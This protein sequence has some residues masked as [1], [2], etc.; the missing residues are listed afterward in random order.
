MNYSRMTNTS[1]ATG[2]GT[3]NVTAPWLTRPNKPAQR[4]NLLT[5]RY[6]TKWLTPNLEI[7][8][9]NTIGPAI[10]M[11]E[12]AF[13]AFARGSL[14][15]T[16]D[17]PVAVEDLHPGMLVDTVGGEPQPLLWI[18]AM[19]LLPASNLPN[20]PVSHLYRIAEGSFGISSGMP[21]LLLGS[22]ARI[23][24][25]GL[26]GDPMARLIS[27]QDLCDGF[28]VIEVTPRAPARVFHLGMASHS[29]IQVNNI[30]TE[31][32]HPGHNPQMQL[33]E[34]MFQIFLSVFPHI[35]RLD[36]FGPLNHLRQVN[37]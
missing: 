36:D 3:R 16:P 29:L 34:E 35:R 2:T 10:P 20:L 14:V 15:Q 31:T 4:P 6:E 23:M 22:G 5:R 12:E 24:R 37:D 21:D 33:S 13:S 30:V 25:S 9:V 28:G 1:L 8:S 18:G 7:Q 26:T 17:G 19:A 27:I 11:F 32:Y